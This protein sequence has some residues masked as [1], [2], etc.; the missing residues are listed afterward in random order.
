MSAPQVCPPPPAAPR[1]VPS[2]PAAAHTLLP[3][4]GADAGARG[5]PAPSLPGGFRLHRLR[6][7]PVSSPQLRP[8]QR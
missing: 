7:L 6:S 8:D 5:P 4:P 2:P 1:P 3:A